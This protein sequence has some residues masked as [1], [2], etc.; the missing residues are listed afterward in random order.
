MA[1]KVHRL[2]STLANRNQRLSAPRFPTRA[3][4]PLDS[5]AGHALARASTASSATKMVATTD[6]AFATID[7]LEKSV[8]PAG[9]GFWF[10]SAGFW[11]EEDYRGFVDSYKPNNLINV[12]ITLRCTHGVTESQKC[13]CI[14]QMACLCVFRGFYGMYFVEELCHVNRSIVARGVQANRLSNLV[15]S[16]ALSRQPPMFVCSHLPFKFCPCKSF[17]GVVDLTPYDIE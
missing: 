9:G 16:T 11:G 4:L 13:S 15:S 17:A 14:P 5:F 2:T 10:G 12:R 8:A 6:P 1:C 7:D 3:L